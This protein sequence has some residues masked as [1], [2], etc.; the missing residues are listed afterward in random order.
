MLDR[1]HFDTPNLMVSSNLAIR[2]RK[3]RK[4]L[5]RNK[6]HAAEIRKKRNL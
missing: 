2:Q 3:K 4:A 5:Q 6:E 1:I